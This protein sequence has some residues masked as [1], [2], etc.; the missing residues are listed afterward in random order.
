MKINIAKLSPFAIF[1][2]LLIMILSLVLVS[3]QLSTPSQKNTDIRSKAAGNTL[4]VCPNNDSSCSYVGGDGIQQAIDAAAD[5]DIINI[6]SGEYNR[7]PP[8]NETKC[9]ID[10]KGKSITIKGSG[11]ASL[12]NSQNDEHHYKDIPGLARYGICISGGR[13]TIDSLAIKQPLKPAIDIRQAQVV[14]KNTQFIDID[15]GTIDVRGSKV[16]IV[17][18]LFTG[19]AGPGVMLHDTSHGIIINNTFFGNGGAGVDFDLCKNNEPTGIVSNNLIVNPGDLFSQPISGSGI[20]ADCRDQAQK[21]A[22]IKTSNNF[23]WKGKGGETCGTDLPKRYDD[24]VAGEICQ[25]S[26]VV[27]PELIGADERC[28]VVVHG[29]GI[30][31]G[32]FNTRPTSPIGKAG[33]GY[34]FGPCADANS[35]GCLSYIEQQLA[36]LAPPATPTSSVPTSEPYVLPPVDNIPTSP[37]DDSGPPITYYLPPTMS[38]TNPNQPPYNPPTSG[39]NLPTPTITPTPKPIIDVGKTVESVKNTWTN[40]VNSIIQFTKTILP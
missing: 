34:G 23:V 37:P 14:V 9:L 40:F 5:G 18:N 27:P 30:V 2:P 32:D 21:V 11:S 39:E 3:P 28:T 26:T 12:L 22:N 7:R 20:G 6:A 25:G 17:N 33:A 13:V 4:T 1:I 38:F 31:V 29:E 10:T 35:G 19:S 24:C 16:L 8:S 36:Q 15:N